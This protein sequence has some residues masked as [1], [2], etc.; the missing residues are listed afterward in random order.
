MVIDALKALAQD[1]GLGAQLA[2]M[3]AEYEKDDEHNEGGSVFDL[4][5]DAIKEG[6]EDN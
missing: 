5:L 4:N 3:L 6:E 1:N 2:T